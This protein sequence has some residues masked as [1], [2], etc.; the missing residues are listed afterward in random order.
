MIN[1]KEKLIG[2]ILCGGKSSRMK[3]DKGLLTV[4]DKRWFEIKYESLSKVLSH[5]VISVNSSQYEQY[6][7]FR[8]DLEFVLDSDDSIEGPL[9]GIFS[10]YEKYPDCD[11]FALACDMIGIDDNVVSFLLDKYE[12]TSN[13]EIY[14][15]KNE[16]FLETLCGIYTAN[17]IQKIK[18]EILNQGKKNFAIHKLILSCN[19]LILPVDINQKNKFVNINT[20]EEM[21]GLQ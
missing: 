6:K 10:I 14:M 21:I 1:K 19:S 11:L 8:P 13:K 12:P 7:Q 16:E 17:G 15:Y 3:S 5:V 4:K 20:R 9:R 2:V 18:Q